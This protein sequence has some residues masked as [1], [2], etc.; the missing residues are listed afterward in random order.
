MKSIY[1]SYTL[2][3]NELDSTDATII[4]NTK[5]YNTILELPKELSG[6]EKD[7]VN[8]AIEDSLFV[9]P[10][11]IG[12]CKSIGISLVEGEYNANKIID[13]FNVIEFD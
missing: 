7:G 9:L 5:G 10:K 1:N 6:H 3:Y 8:Y 12:N 13:C 2:N 11:N 4:N